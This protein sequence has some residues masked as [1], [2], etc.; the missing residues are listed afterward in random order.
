MG[1]K[2]GDVI[3]WWE[4]AYGVVGSLLVHLYTSSVGHY[5]LENQKSRSAVIE[6]RLTRWDLGY[7]PS[8]CLR[9]FQPLHGLLE[10]LSRRPSKHQMV[11][12]HWSQ[13]VDPWLLV[14]PYFL[15]PPAQLC[16]NRESIQSFGFPKLRNECRF[17]VHAKHKMCNQWSKEMTTAQV[18][19]T[20]GDFNDS[21][22]IPIL[23]NASERG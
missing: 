4:L 6:Y 19:E 17:G 20:L 15:F 21:S 11:I 7:E 2:L 8:R 13:T 3:L 1:L 14:D 9:L 16:E 10:G 5:A 18:G 12:Q 23:L 22:I